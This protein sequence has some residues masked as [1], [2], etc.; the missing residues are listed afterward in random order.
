MSGILS[1]AGSGVAVVAIGVGWLLLRHKD[2][3]PG[4]THPWLHR[5]AIVI[6]YCAGVAL[7]FTAAG[8]WVISHILSLSGLVGASTAP[9]SGAGWALITIGSLALLLTVITALIWTPDARYA[10][11]ALATPLVLALAPAGIAHHVFEVTAAP[12]Q[13]LVTN[14]ATWAGG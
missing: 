7:V 6:M 8:Q 1:W 10:W 2:H 5:L 11:I 12:S 14:I 4:V 3:A 9:G 13:Q